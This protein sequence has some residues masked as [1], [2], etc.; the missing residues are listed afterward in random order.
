MMAEIKIYPTIAATINVANDRFCND[1][2]QYMRGYQQYCNLFGALRQD[3]KYRPRRHAKC[4]SA[5][6]TKPKKEA[7]L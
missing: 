1:V 4:L 6:T 2:C 5:P 3:M 7:R